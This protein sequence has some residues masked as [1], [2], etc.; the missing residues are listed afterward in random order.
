MEVITIC[1]AITLCSMLLC[2]V[3]ILM[4]YLLV[5]GWII[6]YVVPVFFLIGCISAIVAVFIYVIQE[7]VVV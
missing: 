4:E 7:G 1:F 2:Y 5:R 6:K 3:A